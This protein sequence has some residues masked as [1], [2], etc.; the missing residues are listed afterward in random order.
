MKKTALLLSLSLAAFTGLAQE[1]EGPIL[2]VP[3]KVF[4]GV[5]P[6]SSRGLGRSR[7]SRYIRAVGP[8]SSVHVEGETRRVPLPGM[9]LAPGPH[10]RSCSSPA[11]SI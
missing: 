4:D 8:A 10:R 2:L 11:T 5:E 3:D 7:R 9:T 6:E 1:P